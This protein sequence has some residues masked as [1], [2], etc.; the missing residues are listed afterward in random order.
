[1]KTGIA[2]LPLH[3]GKAPSWLFQRM[4]RL[5]REI[6]IAVVREYGPQEMLQRLSDPFW[7]QAF[8]CVLGFD[9]HSSGVT[10][11]T[12]GALKEGVKG[13][14]RELGLFIAGGKGGTSRKTPSE[15]IRAG[16]QLSCDPEKLVYASRMSAKVDSSAVQDGYQLYHHSFIFTKSGDWAVV[17]QGMNDTNKYARRYHWLGSRVTNFVV[18]PH[19]AICCDSRGNTLNMVAV[20]SEEARQSAV[21]L[22]QIKPDTLVSEIKKIQNLHLPSRHHVDIRDIHPDRL[23]KIFVKTYEQSP[24]NFESLLGIEGVG[25]KTIRALT[26]IS[27]IVYGKSP[28]FHDPVRYSFAHGGK[29]GHPYPVDKEVYD[30]II[31]ILKNA[32]RQAKVGNSEKVEAIKRLNSF[33]T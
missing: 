23:Y 9:W 30:R 2:H 26:L 28:S 27:E 32:L 13:L 22:S 6:T 21:T 5:A 15:I 8:G 1:M 25:P 29:D 3:G 12:C 17:Q 31:E 20:A 4:K 18:E 19:Q 7:F 11:T 24:E 16:D 33:I 14:E 10:T